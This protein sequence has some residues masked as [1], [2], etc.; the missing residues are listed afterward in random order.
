MRLWACEFPCSLFAA[1]QLNQIHNRIAT[2]KIVLSVR[3]ATV[4]AAEEQQAI[5]AHAVFAHREIDA[6]MRTSNA[7]RKASRGLAA[8]HNLDIITVAVHPN[9]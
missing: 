2:A 9:R 7:P 5:L 6:M 8:E 1:A 3:G 4:N